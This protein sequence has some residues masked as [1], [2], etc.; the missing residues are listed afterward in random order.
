MDRHIDEQREAADLL[1]R[2]DADGPWRTVVWNDPVNLMS[3][4]VHVFR[5]HFGYGSSRAI[6][7]M[8][9]VHEQGR[10]VVSEGS[11]ESVESDVQAMHGY[12][13]RATMERA[14]DGNGD[15]AGAGA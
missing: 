6:R 2:D 5:T 12:G 7:L 15:D 3:Y 14:G 8:R 9:A 10:A 13:L 11:R 4:V 1:V